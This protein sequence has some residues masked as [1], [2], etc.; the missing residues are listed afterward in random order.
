MD[1]TIAEALPQI[2]QAESGPSR[3][4]LHQ[5]F[6][7]LRR[8]APLIG[9]VALFIL[10]VVVIYAFQ[11]TPRYA[12]TA[13][14]M[15]D[16]RKQNVV[17]ISAV[18]SGMPSD[19]TAID[20][21]VKLLKARS[22]AERVV[23]N[24]KLD[25]DPEFNAAL[26][27][28][29]GLGALFSFGR[30]AAPVGANSNATIR[31]REHQAVVDA[32]LA[33]ESVTRDGLTYLMHIT[34][35][36]ESPAKAAQIANVFANQYMVSQLDANFDATQKANDWL[37]GK[38][39][40]LRKQVLDAETQ[41]QQYKIANN[42][43]SADGA[44]LTEQ[45][46]ST[47]DAQL[48][49]TRAQQAEAEARLNTAKS[50][51][52]RGSTGEDVGEA[53]GSPVI[54]QLRAQRAAQSQKVADLEG[55]YGERHPQLLE[56]K[57]E[58]ADIDNQIQQE[59]HRIISNLEAQAQVARERTASVAG[60]VASSKGALA[61]NNRASIGLNELQR[62]ADAAKALY[63]SFLSRFKQTSEQQGLETTN[64]RIV[65]LAK[66]PTEPSYPKKRQIFL[67]GLVLALGAG[68]GAAYVAE[69]LD[70]GVAT[71]EDVERSFSLPY[72]GSIPT[73]ASSIEQGATRE[74]NIAPVDFVVE[75]P[76]SSFSEAF[77]NLRASILFSRVG[78]QVK[79][80]AIT[81][82]LPGEGKTTTAIALARTMGLSGGR[83]VI[84]DCDLRRRGVSRILASDPAAGL[85]EVLNG[86]APLD[87]A[88]VKDVASGAFVLPLAKASSTPKDVFGAQ[89][90]QRLLT[91]LR[92]RFD[93][94]VLDTAPV[95]PLA[96]TRI[97]ATQADVVVMLT[98][99]RKTPRKAVQAALGLL[100]S[101]NAYVSGV[102][103]SQVDLKAQ[104]KYGYGDPGYY[105]QAYKKYYTS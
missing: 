49:Q 86:V 4:D 59:I 41:V 93:V 105:Y 37:N 88:L 39:A 74:R 68:F 51:L 34:F 67:I 83:V 11:L 81:S 92:A 3:V 54:Q 8:R 64:A 84:V 9:G 62:N 61:T 1:G 30:A 99:W 57:R 50:Q 45:E 10:T 97:L 20:T 22:L 82:P 70:S 91:E 96:D 77:R 17:D 56:A 98:R 32:V 72:L 24:L 90:M 52:A 55:R 33:R 73:L 14:V 89:A 23:A 65:S 102:V 48:A 103:L 18:M 40:D 21:E 85:L 100:Q 79:V 15:I 25:Q 44:T 53:L 26:R 58:L 71:A 80:V 47:L 29:T 19:S 42:L 13:D 31:Q 38:V 66:V 87:Q 101:V 12:A 2:D 35:E 6:A 46:I 76:L 94:V 63:E 27:K 78:Q 60:S 75:K 95:L 28:P 36:S 43:M 104:S 7:M 16:P 69:L 5:L